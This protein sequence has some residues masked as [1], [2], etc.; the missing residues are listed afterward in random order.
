MIYVDNPLHTVEKS[1]RIVD[2]RKTGVDN[3][4]WCR[5]EQEKDRDCKCKRSIRKK[6][7]NAAPILEA[8]QKKVLKPAPILEAAQKKVLNATGASAG[9]ECTK[10]RNR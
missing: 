7:L 6:V 10:K 9:K 4:A 2:K 5:K 3:R 8:A 1:Q